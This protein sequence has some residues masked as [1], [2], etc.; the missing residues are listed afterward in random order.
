M[1][2]MRFYRFWNRPLQVMQ[3]LEIILNQF[4]KGKSLYRQKNWKDQGNCQILKFNA[5]K[6]FFSKI[7]LDV[8]M[9]VDIVRA[10]SS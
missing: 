8:V 1:C 10:L 9:V 7:A 3:E 4:G 5:V 2:I 6:Y